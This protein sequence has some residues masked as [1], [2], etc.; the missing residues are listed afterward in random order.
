MDGG[1]RVGH[2]DRLRTAVLAGD[3]SAWRSWY[4]ATAPG[5]RAYVHWRCGGLAELADDVVQETWLTAVRRV[6]TFRPASG[7]F[8]SWICGIAANVIRNRLR[9]R[10]PL[11]P[12][13]AAPF[14]HAGHSRPGPDDTAEQVAR[15][16]AAL[17]P[18][19]EGVLRAK[20]L[21]GLSVQD[22]ADRRGDSLKAIESLLTRARQAFRGAYESVESADG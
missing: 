10:R 5:L 20:Y 8:A 6:R 15:A 17:P 4:D 7:P 9:K 22:I 12:R 19:Y 18:H 2:E 21:D 16:L 3:E 14:A 1:D 11:D 13:M